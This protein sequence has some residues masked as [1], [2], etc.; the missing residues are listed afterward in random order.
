MLVAMHSGGVLTIRPWVLSHRRHFHASTTPQMYHVS[1][2][3]WPM[4]PVADTLTPVPPILLMWS[5]HER[6]STQFAYLRSQISPTCTTT[7]KTCKTTPTGKLRSHWLDPRSSG[8][9]IY[10]NDGKIHTDWKNWNWNDPVR[11]HY[12]SALYNMLFR[13]ELLLLENV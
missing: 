1:Q 8:S 11:I 10:M 9:T 7:S 4:S 6:C 13:V 2:V 12:R 3:L 5:H